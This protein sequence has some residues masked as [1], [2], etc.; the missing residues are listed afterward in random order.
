MVRFSDMLGGT[1]DADEPSAPK[2]DR[3]L[4]TDTAADADADEQP[5]VDASPATGTVQF[6]DQVGAPAPGPTVVERPAPEPAAQSPQDVLDRLR[7]TR[8]RLEPRAHRARRTRCRSGSTSAP[9]SRRRPEAVAHSQAAPPGQSA[10]ATNPRAATL[11]A[12]T[13]SASRPRRQ[14]PPVATVRGR[15]AARSCR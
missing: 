6:V 11:A 15:R 3:D 7:G 2:S 8:R 10:G 9:W 12:G 14:A 5:D 1:G 13:R 4:A